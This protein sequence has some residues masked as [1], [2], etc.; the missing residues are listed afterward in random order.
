LPLLLFC[1]SSEHSTLRAVQC[2]V[3]IHGKNRFV[4]FANKRHRLAALRRRA[5]RRHRPRR[6]VCLSARLKLNL[7]D[8]AI[9]RVGVAFHFSAAGDQQSTRNKKC[10]Q[11]QQF[12][13]TRSDPFHFSL[14]SPFAGLA[15]LSGTNCI[16]ARGTAT[17]RLPDRL[18]YIFWFSAILPWIYNPALISRFREI[19]RNLGQPRN[20]G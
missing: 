15:E 7:H 10:R 16:N 9:S 6:N 12:R 14:N 5:R 18:A 8:S 11:R 13:T 3:I 20:S 2:S 17:M 19:R 1:Q 4:A